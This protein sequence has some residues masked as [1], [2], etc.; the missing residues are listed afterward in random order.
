MERTSILKIERKAE[1]LT[2]IGLSRSNLN[3]K[4]KSGVWCPPISL[5][6]RAVGFIE[7]ESNELLAAYA[8]G[9]SGSEIQALVQKLVEER[10]N[11]GALSNE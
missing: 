4:V 8:N 10:K 11:L 5:G 9:Y 2:R 7:Y 6:E 3:L 1:L